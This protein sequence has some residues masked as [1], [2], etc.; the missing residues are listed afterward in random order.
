MKT[1]FRRDK[2]GVSLWPHSL[3]K[4]ALKQDAMAYSGVRRIIQNF[5]W[6]LDSLPVLTYEDLGYTKAKEKQLMRNYYN[7]DEFL[8][9][10]TI[11]EKRAGKS[12]LTSVALLLRSKP[13]D[14]RSMGHCMLNM[15][16]SRLNR[17]EVVDMYYRST[18]LSFKFGA[19]LVFL[20][21]V[22]TE[23]GINPSKIRFHFANAFLS[24]GYWGTLMQFW[25]PIALLSY[26]HDKDHR[27]FLSGTRV[28]F[29]S[30]IEK[31]QTYKYSPHNQQHRLLW[32]VLTPKQ[33]AEI[34]KFLKARGVKAEVPRDSLEDDEE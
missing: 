30:A 5:T 7:A 3:I 2:G 22:F 29:R 1:I 17:V 31:N 28:L 26:L 21:R 10:K 14:S 9:V 11:L 19:D 15:V 20:H 13:K 24:G 33:L 23:L 32:R 34:A 12:S 16:I 6:E 25:D 18:E 4:A 8:R 27:F